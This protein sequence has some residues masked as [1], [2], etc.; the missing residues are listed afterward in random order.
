[1]IIFCFLILKKNSAGIKFVLVR[2]RSC[3]NFQAGWWMHFS[4]CLAELSVENL[5]YIFWHTGFLNRH[6]PPSHATNPKGIRPKIWDTPTQHSDSLGY[7]GQATHHLYL[8]IPWIF[9]Y[10][11]L[12][13]SNRLIHTILLLLFCLNF[14]KVL[15][16][17]KYF[18]LH[19]E[20][21]AVAVS[22]AVDGYFCCQK[23]TPSYDS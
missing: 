5:G 16:K 23:A 20:K 10:L 22:V 14:M 6:P 4:N 21:R 11:V 12:H 3:Q 15:P 18:E 17:W 1:M 2:I 13:W 8:H 9:K 7:F 19:G